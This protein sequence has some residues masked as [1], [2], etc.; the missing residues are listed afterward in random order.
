MPHRQR[1]LHFGGAVFDTPQGTMQP[2]DYVMLSQ[3]ARVT[4][5]IPGSFVDLL[6]SYHKESG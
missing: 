6:V 2:F 1:F 3:A 4:A 5:G